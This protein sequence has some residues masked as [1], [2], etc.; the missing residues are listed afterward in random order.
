MQKWAYG[1][2]LWHVGTDGK[3][4]AYFK[5]YFFSKE[6]AHEGVEEPLR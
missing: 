6:T 4:I 1:T 2:L 3:G 5:E